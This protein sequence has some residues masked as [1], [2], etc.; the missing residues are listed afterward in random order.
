MLRGTSAHRGGVV[1]MSRYAQMVY[2]ETRDYQYAT[3]L[4]ST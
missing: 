4:A 3:S 2:L 1:A